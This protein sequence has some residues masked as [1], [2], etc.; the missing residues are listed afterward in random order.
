[1]DKE[2]DGP[3]VIVRSASPSNITPLTDAMG[4][5]GKGDDV[6]MTP[7]EPLPAAL[8]GR[9]SYPIYITLPPYELKEF[10]QSLNDEWKSRANDFVFFSGTKVCGVVEP[11]LREF[12]MCRDAMTQ[13]SISKTSILIDKVSIW[14]CAL[15][16]FSI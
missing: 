6:I 10:I 8:G 1:M 4:A 14:S 2:D 3:S 16:K 12:G 9:E 5:L 13:V 15:T 11:V 7:N